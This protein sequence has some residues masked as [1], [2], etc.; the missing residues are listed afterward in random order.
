MFPSDEDLDRRVKVLHH[1]VP[2]LMYNVKQIDV[3]QLTDL[4]DATY[5]D[6]SAKD[7][8]ADTTALSNPEA[9]LPPLDDVICTA[10]ISDI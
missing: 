10:S 5:L 1:N 3:Q 9:V 8:A 4:P 7:P 6:V 2:S